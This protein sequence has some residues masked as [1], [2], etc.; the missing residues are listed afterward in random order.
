MVPRSP[1]RRGAGRQ[2]RPR[3]RRCYGWRRML[4]GPAGGMWLSS[5]GRRLPGSPL[6]RRSARAFRCPFRRRHH[7]GRPGG[8]RDRPP[9]RLGRCPMG[10]PLPV[11]R[12]R[13]GG[14]RAGRGRRRTSGGRRRG[15]A[16]PRRP[17][18][19]R[20]RRAVGGRLAGMGPGG[21]PVPRRAAPRRRGDAG[22]TGAGVSQCAVAGAAGASG[23]APGPADRRALLRERRI[24][25][26]PE[27]EDM[28][29]WRKAEIDRLCRQPV[30]EPVLRVDPWAGLPGKPAPGRRLPSPDAHRPNERGPPGTP[31]R[32]S[33][34]AKKR[35]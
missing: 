31:G 29:D 32:A 24:A 14:R 19:G 6:L 20:S 10:R 5:P 3:I 26:L 21:A 8:P 23:R 1:V 9:A 4:Q 13:A 12:A 28:A 11:R 27:P 17:G 34:I 15:R 35:V 2:G 33:F 30:A 22:R 7:E 16:E 25:S 18:R